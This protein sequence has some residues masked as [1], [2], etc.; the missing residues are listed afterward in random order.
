MNNNY[1]TSVPRA[2]MTLYGFFLGK[3]NS[4]IV[5]VQ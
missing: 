2:G 4:G 1:S 5:E 3:Q